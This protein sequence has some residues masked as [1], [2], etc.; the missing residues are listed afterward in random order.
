MSINLNLNL[1]CQ[2]FRTISIVEKISNMQNNSPLK[3]PDGTEMYRW[4]RD[5]FPICRSISG[6]GVRETLVYLKGI[7]PQLEI[8]SVPSGTKAFDWEVPDEWLINEAYV[9]DENGN[10]VI[11]FKNNTLHVVSYSEP[12]NCK[13]HLNELQR[14]LHSIPDLPSAIP[15]V[16][17]YYK[18][19]WGFCLC[20]NQRKQ[21][22]SGEYRVFIDSS[23][24]PGVLNFGELII[25][26]KKEEEIFLSTYICHPSMANNELSGP[27]VATALAKWVLNLPDRNYT[28]RIVFIPETIGSIVYLS[29]NLRDLKKNVVA[30]FNITCVGDDLCYSYLPSRAGNTLSDRVAQHVLMHLAPDFKKYSYLDRGSDER[31]YCSPGVDLPIASIMRSKYHEYP[32]YHTSLDDLSFVSPSGLQGSFDALS[33]AI[34]AIEFNPR[35]RTTVLCEPQLGKR[36]LY[37]TLS[38]K[39]SS[40]TVKAM[41]NL[42]A[43]SDGTMSLLEIAEVIGEPVWEIAPIFKTLDASGLLYDATLNK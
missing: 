36:G 9:E 2:K 37:P 39:R 35:P 32:E 17:S 16:T 40:Q 33:K 4:L 22:K 14:N 29:Q 30:G 11:D 43:Y 8:K 25:P 23:L 42:I 26:G 12:V 18:K 41:M 10:K 34:A 21:L 27:V 19:T 28:Y 7:I 1:T 13:I 5:L 31:Q 20:E 38:S 24:H 15:Y 3:I 6:K